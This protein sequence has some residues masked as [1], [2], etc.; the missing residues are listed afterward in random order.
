MVYTRVVGVLSAPALGR[1]RWAAARS[2]TFVDGRLCR[3]SVVVE[4]AEAQVSITF[5]HGWHRLG[6]TPALVGLG[7]AARRVRGFGDFWRHCLDA[8]A[9]ADADADV[10]PYDLA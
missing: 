7:Q 4:L 5:S 9:D 10:A 8:D 6:L 2:G 1:R 3:V